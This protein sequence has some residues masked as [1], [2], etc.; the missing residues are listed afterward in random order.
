MNNVFINKI[1]TN[2]LTVH[3]QRLVDGIDRRALSLKNTISLNH[4][5]LRILDPSYIAVGGYDF[6]PIA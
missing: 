4:F 3:K 1:I 5:Q 2:Y 6:V